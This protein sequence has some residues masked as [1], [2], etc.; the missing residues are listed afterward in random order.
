MSRTYRIGARMIFALVIFTALT[1]AIL[2]R[3]QKTLTE[4]DQPL[5]FSVASDLIHYGVFGNGW[6]ADDER[7]GAA[8]A[9]GLFFGPTYPWMIV[10][11]AKVDPR[12]AQAVDCGADMYRQKRP[13]GS[14][15][16][17]VWPMLVIHAL[18]LTLGALAIARAGELLFGSILFFWIAG[19]AATAGLLAEANQF[20]FVMTDATAFALYGLAMLAMV[21]GWT[22]SKRR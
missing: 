13:Y 1:T 6:F 17:H 21:L 5:Y 20:S 8:P 22:R 4:F 2:T 9:P 16:V 12:F 10:V 7:A 3:P 15:E 11:L 14:C 18:L 19:A